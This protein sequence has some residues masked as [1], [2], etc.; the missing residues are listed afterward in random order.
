MD[1]STSL[2]KIA[3]NPIGVWGQLD[4]SGVLKSSRGTFSGLEI[5]SA[6][7]IFGPRF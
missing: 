6:V 7:Q 5:W 1:F 3:F 4:L 2:I